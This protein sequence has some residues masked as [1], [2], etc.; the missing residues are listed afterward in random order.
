MEGTEHLVSFLQRNKRGD[1]YTD[2][3]IEDNANFTNHSLG[4]KSEDVE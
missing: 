4:E 2:I 1:H 3:C